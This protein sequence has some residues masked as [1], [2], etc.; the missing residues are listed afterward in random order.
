MGQALGRGGSRGTPMARRA[1]S[2]GGDRRGR[3]RG[4]DP[5]RGCRRAGNVRGQAARWHG[6]IR[7][8]AGDAPSRHG[9][10]RGG[11]R[12]GERHSSGRGR[13][14]RWRLAGFRA[15]AA[16]LRPPH[17]G[18]S[19]WRRRSLGRR[20]RRGQIG[21]RRRGLVLRAR[22]PRTRGR[23][24]G[25]LGCR[26]CPHR[27]ERRDRPGTADRRV[28]LERPVARGPHQ[29]ADPPRGDRRGASRARSRD[30]LCDRS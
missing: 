20:G 10:A 22:A 29:T 9:S 25:R 23:R 11:R 6:F 1:G 8:G 21:R 28:S 18:R 15:V 19:G 17:D 24:T 13:R 30:E 14:G 27:G 3:C 26:R 4:D 2:M 5:F 16:G 12:A 7:G